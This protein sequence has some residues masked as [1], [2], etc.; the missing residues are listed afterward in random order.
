[1]FPSAREDPPRVAWGAL[2]GAGDTRFPLYIILTGLIGVR[3][4]LAGLAAWL[5]WPVEWVF[6]VLIF[7]YMVRSA[8]FTRRFARGRWK[9]L[10]AN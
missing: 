8:L 7:D 4:T 2:R 10:G 3:V 5:Q 9:A 6:A 1:M